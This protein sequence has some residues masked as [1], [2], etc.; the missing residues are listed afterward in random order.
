MIKHETVEMNL[1]DLKPTPAKMKDAQQPPVCVGPE[2]EMSDGFMVGFKTKPIGYAWLDPK[3]MS[4][5]PLNW[6]I[7]PEV[8]LRELE[9]SLDEFGWLPSM[10]A[11]F[12]KRTGKVI[13]AHGRIEVALNSGQQV[14]AAIIDVDEETEKR[15][16]ASMDR[17]G[18]MH[19]T[20]KLALA[21]LL[22]SLAGPMPAGYEPD[23]L[24]QL[25][26]ALEIPN[27]L[28]PLL[29]EGI[30]DSFQSVYKPGAEVT[31]PHCEKMFKLP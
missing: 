24:Q 25:L 28:P 10:L 18:E 13:D 27:Q 23:A 29:D 5:H 11:L 20:D 19:D 8:Q 14:P 1:K 22:K 30:A 9:K 7:H 17:V 4:P 31:C 26:A 6:K 3:T 16:L 15:I 12:N 21:E 2:K